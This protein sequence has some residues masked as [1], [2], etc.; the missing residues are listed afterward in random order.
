MAPGKNPF[1]VQ[2]EFFYQR[3]LVRDE[4]CLTPRD[5]YYS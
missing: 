2:S 5:L 1:G 3:L 4:T